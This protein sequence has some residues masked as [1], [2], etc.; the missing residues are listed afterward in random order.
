MHNGFQ[1]RYV[2]KNQVK[3]E[4]RGRSRKIDY[5]LFSSINSPW[6]DMKRD[7]VF[8]SSKRFRFKKIE[9]SDFRLDTHQNDRS[10][11]LKISNLNLICVR[12]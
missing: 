5:S 6:V 10:Q 7:T 1:L 2:T 9:E 4:F 8:L 12:V 3:F 11:G